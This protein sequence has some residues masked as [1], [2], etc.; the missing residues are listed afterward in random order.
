[1]RRLFVLI[2]AA[3]A[4][5]ILARPEKWLTDF[6]QAFYLSIAYDLNHHG[7]FSNG[8][9]DNVD[10]R[11]QASH[12]ELTTTFQACCVATDSRSQASCSSPSTSWLR[13]LAA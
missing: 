12:H 10:M 13:R 6:D 8:V 3:L 2:F 9:F 7:V 11:S 5:A 1:M 4:A